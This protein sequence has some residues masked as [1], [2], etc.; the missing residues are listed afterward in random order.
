MD[1]CFWSASTDTRPT[2]SDD[3]RGR[4]VTL[5]QPI[6]DA[7]GRIFWGRP[8]ARSAGGTF[9]AKEPD[10]PGLEPERTPEEGVLRATQYR[11]DQPGTPHLGRAIGDGTTPS[12]GQAA[13]LVQQLIEVLWRRKIGP[14]NND[15]LATALQADHQNAPSEPSQR[16]SPVTVMGRMRARF[17]DHGPSMTGGGAACRG[18][19]DG[20]CTERGLAQTSHPRSRRSASSSSE[21]RQ[22]RLQLPK[23]AA[24]LVRGPAREPPQIDPSLQLIPPTELHDLPDKAIG[25]TAEG[26]QP[27]HNDVGYRMVARL[28]VHHAPSLSHPTAT[29]LE[30]AEAPRQDRRAD[31]EVARSDACCGM[32]SANDRS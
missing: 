13:W 5:G 14:G 17:G 19:T 10:A 32:V 15:C 20:G 22:M 27:M 7:A 23:V 28:A 3:R 21:V 30:L 1:D 6:S 12:V 29:P 9:N 2:D 4:V 31:T 26:R 24:L 16:S 8:T 18:V 25:L 11:A